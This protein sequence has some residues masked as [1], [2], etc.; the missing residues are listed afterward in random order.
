MVIE[1]ADYNNIMW[2]HSLILQ[3]V[4]EHCLA[5]CLPRKAKSFFHMAF[6]ALYPDQYYRCQA[7]VNMEYFV[8]SLDSNLVEVHDRNCF[9]GG[10]AFQ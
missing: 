6:L 4:S 1:I 3:I 5:A 2:L 7:Q 8:K 10:F 9:V